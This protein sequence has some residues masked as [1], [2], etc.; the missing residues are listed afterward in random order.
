LADTGWM[1]LYAV[2]ASK[3][4]ATGAVE[5]IYEHEQD[6]RAFAVA[7]STDHG[8]LAASVT[9]FTLGRLGSRHPVAWYARGK[10]QDPRAPRPGGRYY[11][12]AV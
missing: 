7:R 2:H 8:V 4:D 10:L 11:P 6:A 5:V 12:S 1:D 9:R 3:P